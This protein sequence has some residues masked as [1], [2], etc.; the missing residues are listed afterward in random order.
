MQA[1]AFAPDGK[2][3]VSTGGD[4]L[5][6]RWDVATGREIGTFGQQTDRDKPFAP[7]RWMHA[8]A[9]SPDGK[10]LA[11][12][13]Y[14]D[15]WQLTTIR[16]W[17]AASGAQTRVLQGHTDGILSVAWSPDG[18]T[19]ASASADGTL[20]LWD[21]ATGAERQTLAGHTGAVRCVAWSRDGKRLASAGADGTVRL[22]DADKATELRSLTAHA[23]GADGVDFS[24]D[25]KRLVSGGADMTVRV[26]EA[27]TG[28]ELRSMKGD[29]P[30][31]SVAFSPGGQLVAAGAKGWDVELWDPDSGREVRRLKGLHNQVFSV[32]FSPDG[33]HVAAASGYNSLVCV[34]ETETGKR[35]GEAP[36]HEAGMI[37]RLAYSAD[38]RTITSSSADQTI[39]QWDA[40]TGRQT[41]LIAT[42]NAT[43]RAAMLS[44]D[45]KSVVCGSWAGDLRI[46]DPAGK[47]VRR[48]KAHQGQI[49]VLS[50]SP[51][52]K[53]LASAGADQAVVLW[54]AATGKERRRFQAE[55]GL[56]NEVTFS[57]DGRL[58]CVVV[59][60]LPVQLWEVDS[61]KARPL[62]REP[63]GGVGGAGGG[64][65]ALPGGD[66]ES[67][68][69]SPDGRLIATGGRDGTA[70]V[71]DVASGRQ[72]RALPGHLGWLM[73]VAFSAD[74][75]TLAV[76]NWRNVRLWE[77]AT[78]QE[79]KRLAGHEG[80]VTA[81]AFAPDGRTMV[82][83]GSETTALVWDLT[84]R[85]DGG[86]FRTAELSPRD[87]EVA[88]TD[89]RGDDA[90]RAYRALWLLALA[91]KQALPL[92]RDAL[93]RAKPADADRIAQLV[94]ALDDD[95]FEKRERATEELTRMGEQAEP[96]LKKALEGKPSVE[97][98]RRVEYLREQTRAGGDSGERLRQA[99]ALEVV[100]AVGT[101]EARALLEELAKGADGAWLTGEARAALARLPK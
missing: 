73:S 38:G 99:R 24:P 1:V 18:K 79:R 61:G 23:G 66:V 98:R 49:T 36:G 42:P 62:V 51:D 17:D 35:L 16:L 2:S 58:L 3:L 12:G 33:K 11:T 20:R 7:T 84:G 32:A 13:D 54:D 45:G 4:H 95:D 101:P 97:L 83:G 19:L 70:R 71:W 93:P 46:L 82:S 44:P 74:G 15:G 64:V 37:T 85:W 10:T 25:G 72:V 65:A 6:R 88:W 92:L 55:G 30:V 50:Y 91:P 75:R 87:L 59:R 53:L 8:A 9:F 28:K 100:E 34:W 47:E 21:P 81:L 40:L 26:W 86:R 60:G 56:P 63:A 31:R 96:A 68:A 27:A 48:W 29:K 43:A 69:F 90:G 52:G 57:P 80:D 67:A 41:R 5:A 22:W 94:A 76:A 14:N 77:V 78:G 39:R 89:L